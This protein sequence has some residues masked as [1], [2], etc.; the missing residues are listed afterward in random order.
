MTDSR[1][2]RVRTASAL[3]CAAASFGLL[4]PGMAS[5]EE[6]LLGIGARIGPTTG[7]GLEASYPLSP[8]FDLRAGGNF[9]TFKFDDED[10]G[11]EFRAKLKYSSFAGF[12][13]YKPFGG[14]FRISGGL[15]SNPLKLDLQA[16]G[17]DDYEFGDNDYN[18]DGDVDGKIRLGDA[19]PYLGIGWG[20]TTSGSGFGASFDVGVQ[21]GKSP[22]ASLEVRGRACDRGIDE[23]CDPNGPSGFSI[24]D[25]SPA[26]TAFQ[27]SIDDEVR[28]LEDDAKDFKLIPVATFGVHYRFGG[29]R[30]A[31]AAPM[32]STAPPAQ[33]AAVPCASCAAAARSGATGLSSRPDAEAIT[34]PRGV[35]L[36][37][38]PLPGNSSKYLAAGSRVEKSDRQVNASGAWWFVQSTE[39]LGGWVPEEELR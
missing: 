14:G 19:V 16:S 15:Y 22:N 23:D 24:D 18:V 34:L 31:A 3:L 6:A 20:G 11:N 5:A 2:R 10:D 26:A 4:T 29:A 25:G 39:G 32:A 8:Y 7:I 28:E 27:Q 36:R 33:P 21:F 9:G 30:S 12:V 37:S 35:T 1:P 38:S 17:E 13:D